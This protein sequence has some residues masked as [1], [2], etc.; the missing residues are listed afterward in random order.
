VG[1]DFAHVLWRLAMGEVVEPIRTHAKAAWGH[2]SRDILAA[3]SE[4]LA[5]TLSPGSYLRSHGKPLVFA[6]FAQDDWLQGLV[7]RPLVVV[8]VLT[9]YARGLGSSIIQMRSTS[10][11]A[12]FAG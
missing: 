11:D 9:R 12:S 2:A 6:A 5:G 8:R 1:I 10:E 7:D 4:M 3:G